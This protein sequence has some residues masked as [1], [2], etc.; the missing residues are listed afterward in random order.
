M[1]KDELSEGL[2]R[3]IDNYEANITYDP[4]YYT[5]QHYV[6][7]LTD[8]NELPFWYPRIKDVGFR[9]PETKTIQLPLD[10]FSELLIKCEDVQPEL[11]KHLTDFIVANWDI[12]PGNLDINDKLFFKFGTSSGKFMFTN[13][14]VVNGSS[15]FAKAIRDTLYEGFCFNKPYSAYLVFREFIETPAE[16]SSIYRGL[17]L[18]T[19]FRIFY[20]FDK[21]EYLDGFNYWGDHDAMIFN[22]DEDQVANYEK[23]YPTLEKDF[24]RLIPELH[25]ECEE[26]LRKVNLCG[27]WS[28]DF[29]WTGS[30]FVLID[31]AVMHMSYFSDKVKLPEEEE[32]ND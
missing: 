11:E 19:E 5:R 32:I 8:V 14:C 31:M 26:K 12:T 20:D 4:Y 15:T 3:S 27:R 1:T 23:A 29:M 7:A 24:H 9:T 28:V 16:R 21:K 13:N 22:M 18:N 30:E 25:K 10:L 17:K 2:Q 6:K